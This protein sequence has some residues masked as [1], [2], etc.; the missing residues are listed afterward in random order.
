MEYVKGQR[1]IILNFSELF[2]KT[3]VEVLNSACFKDVWG[4]F[5][6]N[7][8]KTEN[9]VF[10]KVLDIFTDPVNEFINLFKL[11][12]SFSVEE[13]KSLN[14]FYKLALDRADV[15]YELV[16]NFYDY[17]RKLERYSVIFSKTSVDGV[18]SSSF[19]DAQTEFTSVI[20]KTYRSISEKLSGN[21][22]S[23]YRQLPAGINAGLLISKHV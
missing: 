23:I 3:E 2:C 6:S 10:L 21:K 18:A 13:I 14:P 17:W 11:L 19:I 7:I 5:I 9:Q 1:Q 12:L 4:K 15:I 16:E 20:L 8:Y 22:F